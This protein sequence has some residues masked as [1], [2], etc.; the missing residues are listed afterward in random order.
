MKLKKTL[1]ITLFI[2]PTIFF[3]Q[4]E[5]Q[6]NGVTMHES[7]TTVQSK[8]KDIVATSELITVD[9]T[10]F[11]LAKDKEQHLICSE[12]KTE[13]GTISKAVFTFADDQLTNI[14]ARGNVLESLTTKLTDIAINYMDYTVYQKQMLLINNKKDIAWIMTD[15]AMFSHLFTWENPLLDEKAS[16]ALPNTGLVPAFLQMGASF[17]ELQ[18]PFKANST[19]T[20]RQ[21]LDGSDPNAQ[22]QINCF[23]V[24]YLGFPR[25]AEARFGD[26]KLNV[27]W[28]LLGK[29]EEDRVRQA[30]IKQYGPPIFTDD[31]WEVYNNWQVAQRK[32]KPEILLMTQEIG[33]D[34]KT[35]YFKQ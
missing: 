18:A 1:L 23:G 14:E 27:V 5:Q 17:E 13:T 4:A 24:N 26:D 30:L 35:S 12:L 20:L 29:A 33:L 3:A 2:I 10:I 25:K 31:T 15:E 34:Y 6:F 9:N 22:Y 11:P 32:D 16:E 8:L 21:D 7:L 19:F 28:I